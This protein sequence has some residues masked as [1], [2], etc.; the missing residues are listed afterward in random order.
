MSLLAALALMAAR[1]AA[2][3]PYR[4]LG[5]AP[6][7]QATINSDFMSFLTPGREMLVIETPPRQETELGFAHSTDAFSISIEHAVCRDTLTNA[8]FAD[9]VTVRVGEAHYEGC[10]GMPLATE[11]P[12]PYGAAGSEPFWGLEIANGRITFD[13]DGQVVIVRAPAP[14]VTGNN[15][16]RRYNAPGISILLKRENCELEDARTYADAVTVTVGGRTFEGCGGR[17]IRD[18]PEG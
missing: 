13:N 17:V 7:W 12:P 16:R 11:V 5:A 6:L 8:P 9:R 14:L 1:A 10:G 15:S 2:P 3:E 18:A 4:A